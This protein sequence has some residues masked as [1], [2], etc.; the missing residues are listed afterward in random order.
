MALVNRSIGRRL[1]PTR[2]GFQ[3]CPLKSRAR[4]LPVGPVPESGPEVREQPGR[5]GNCRFDQ[6]REAGSLATLEFNLEQ[7]ARECSYM[8]IRSN[9]QKRIGSHS[10]SRLRCAPAS[11]PVSLGIS[12]SRFD[13]FRPRPGTIVPQYTPQ[14]QHIMSIPWHAALS[15]TASRGKCPAPR[16]RDILADLALS[17]G[18]EY[19]CVTDLAIA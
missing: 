14:R 8:N 7:D 13:F 1:C 15:E 11:R 17:V 9:N 10:F 4:G 2:G 6:P 3:S 19:W 5:P 18:G 12:H 16:C